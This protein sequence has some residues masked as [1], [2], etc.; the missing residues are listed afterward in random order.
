MALS[1]GWTFQSLPC[2]R[3]DLN[4]VDLGFDLEPCGR[5]VYLRWDPRNAVRRPSGVIA[6]AIMQDLG[7]KIGPTLGRYCILEQVGAGG[8]G[9]VYRAHDKQLERDV[10]VKVLPPGTLTDESARSRFRKEALALAR[11]NHPNIATVHEFSTQDNV[12]F[13]VTEFVPGTT[14]E[15]KLAQGAL[16]EREVLSVA[17]QLA[18]GMEAAHEQNV[19]H[20]DLKPG[21]LRVMPNGRLKI[22]DFGLAKLLPSTDENAQ[23]ASIAES[24]ELTTGTLPYMPPEQLRGHRVDARADIWSAG[25]VLYELATGRR[26]FDEKV[27][28]ALVDDIIHKSPKPPRDLNSALSSGLERV[29]LKCLQ[30][31]PSQRYGSAAE[32][33]NDLERVSTGSAPVVALGSRRPRL[34]VAAIATV[35]L[36]TAVSWIALQRRGERPVSSRFRPRR[37]VAVLGFKD[38]SGKPEQAWLSTALSEM[39]TSEL[40]AGESMRAVSGED[41]AR[42][43]IDMGLPATDA[44]AQD[45][46][47]S[48][49]KALGSDLVV[50]GSYLSVGDQLRLDL[51]L[52]DA[53]AGETIITLSQTGS[54][55]QLL[56]LVSR[57]GD[58]LRQKLGIAPISSTQE[59][60]L[61]T[62]QPA[63]PE[64]TRAYADGLAKL[65]SFDA[66]TARS[67][68][69]SAVKLDDNFA[70]AHS[71]LSQAW[72]QLGYDQ[73][74]REE[75]KRAFDLSTGLSREDRLVIEGRY[76]TATKDWPKAIEVYKSLYTFFPDNLEYGLRL[77]D[78]QTHGGKA[79][80]ALATIEDLRKLP[81]PTSDDPRIDLQEA[82]SASEL[83]DSHRKQSAA[84]RAEQKA[85]S[86]GML[87]LAARARDT[88]GG[89]LYD[90]G[91]PKD[92]MSSYQDALQT[93]QRL[94]DRGQVANV[95]FQVSMALE[96][97]GDLASARKMAE[98]SLAI[99]QEIGNLNG[100]ALALNEIAI[101]MRHAGDFPGAVKAVEKSYL[102]KKEIGDKAGMIAAK[103]NLANILDDQ[104]NLLGAQQSYQDALQL[105]QEIGNKRFEAITI[106]NLANVRAKQGEIPQAIQDF[107]RAI[108][109]SRQIGN[110]FSTIWQL[111][112]LAGVLIDSG[113]LEGAD[114]YSG[115]ALEMA[116]TS[117]E[118]AYIAT[119]LQLRGDIAFKKGDLTT[120]R[121]HYQEALG[122]FRKEGDKN[123]EGQ[124]AYV[125]ADLA[126]EQGNL[127]EAEQFAR[128]SVTELDREKAQPA[129][130]AHAALARVL[131]AQGKLKEA[132]NEI[133]QAKATSGITHNLIVLYPVQIVFA[134]VQA[135]NDSSAAIQ[136]LPR[137]IVDCKKRQ[138]VD[139]E[140]EA[141]L[142]L[143]ETQMRSDPKAGRIT[144]QTLAHDAE[145]KGFTFMAGKAAAATKRAA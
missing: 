46:L 7:P 42:L 9:V 54:E 16:S 49:H 48:I 135:E 123:S 84:E 53:V 59:A 109:L 107:Q 5:P 12:D 17:V 47:A 97:L 108:E 21:N 129:S 14:L 50:L 104:G 28:T 143:G 36:L 32:L 145:T 91:Q 83:S 92:A 101:I 70:L 56:E 138:F 130:L 71:S 30:K 90:L 133:L 2:H 112:A 139:Y 142:V 87:L 95:Y 64:A 72:S 103:G 62:A 105:A 25:V 52:Q 82:S 119:A 75:A 81:P 144:L 122:G 140:F 22:L 39:L 4:E 27:P 43:K 77:A 8:M 137:L 68:L 61:K 125:L 57:T 58:E 79:K 99:S 44:L 116:R 134:R 13:L 67:L 120:A 126:R 20:R 141:R 124:A 128:Q 24:E 37:S 18:Q 65:R 102:L 19:L 106:G 55:G 118:N 98:Q 85:K 96:D 69:Q 34:F 121:R 60:Q 1:S 45:T 33:R 66:L 127:A 29:I 3:R 132:Q 131:L 74:A 113:D 136:L 23:T 51:R 117:G 31:D 86:A 100:Q 93:Y 35:L 114:K 88:V 73:K 41:V 38:L 115:E 76:L 94:G 26:P 11:L 63:N 78:A 15:T 111:G 89:A 10:A 6:L 80:D 110:K 40:A